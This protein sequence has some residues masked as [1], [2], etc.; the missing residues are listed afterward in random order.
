MTKF[1]LLIFILAFLF[2]VCAICQTAICEDIVLDNDG[3]PIDLP[4]DIYCLEYANNIIANEYAPTIRHMADAT[5]GFGNRG[6]DGF[7]DLIVSPFYDGD[8]NTGN[9]WNNLANIACCDI[10]SV[11]VDAFDPY[12]YYSVVWLEDYWLVTYGF[13]HPRDWALGSV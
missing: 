4:T 11:D 13:Y 3:L 7:A 10:S 9:N 5:G 12:V 1:S 8:Y 6:L 2:P